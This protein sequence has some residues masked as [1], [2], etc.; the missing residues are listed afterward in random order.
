MSFELVEQ[1]RAIVRGIAYTPAS[2]PELA[3]MRHAQAEAAAS[4]AIEGLEADMVD[5]AFSDMLFEERVPTALRV[6]LSRRFV[7]ELYGTR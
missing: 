2:E 5:A 3:E 1:Y 7:S 4:S 6:D